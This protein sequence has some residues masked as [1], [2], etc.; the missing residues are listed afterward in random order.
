MIRYTPCSQ[1]KFENFKTPFELQLKE[2]NKWVKLAQLIPWDDC[3]KIYHRFLNA[4]Y[5]APSIDT[6]LVLGAIII[7]HMKTLSDRDVVSEIQEN[8]YLQYFVGFSSFDPEPS[9]DPSLFVTFRK[10]LGLEAFEEMNELIVSKALR[11]K[12]PEDIEQEGSNKLIA[13]SEEKQNTAD[14]IA[15][16]VQE[17]ETKKKNKGRLKMDA[18]VADQM[19]VYPTDLGLLN[20]ARLE[21]ERMIDDLYKQSGAKKETEDLSTKWRVFKKLCQN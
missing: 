19:I 9:F 8:I 21:T 14:D 18:T 15:E 17:S 11:I 13:T 4:E 5:G 12:K 1:L 16:P 6:R 20:T 3:A 2:D 7:K 10:R